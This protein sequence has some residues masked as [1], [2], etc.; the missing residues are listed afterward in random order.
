MKLDLRVSDIDH[1]VAN[2]ISWSTINRL[3]ANRRK[4]I[5]ET[6]A[7]KSNISFSAVKLDAGI[8]EVLPG[9]VEGVLAD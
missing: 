8:G 3:N 6:V 1:H 5:C 9:I 4:G 2:Y 7:Q